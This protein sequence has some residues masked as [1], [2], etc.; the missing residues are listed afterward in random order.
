ML[1]SSHAYY[2]TLGRK[3]GTKTK[4]KLSCQTEIE[5][6]SDLSDSELANLC[7]QLDNC[8]CTQHE[9]PKAKP[10][11]TAKQEYEE[12]VKLA[13]QEWKNHMIF[14]HQVD[15]IKHC[16]CKPLPKDGLPERP[17]K[18]CDFL[19]KLHY[20]HCV[21]HWNSISEFIRQTPTRSHAKKCS[22]AFDGCPRH[23]DTMKDWRPADCYKGYCY[24]DLEHENE[25]QRAVLKAMFKSPPCFCDKLLPNHIGITKNYAFGIS[26]EHE[27]DVY[28]CNCS[29]CYKEEV[30][31]DKFYFYRPLQVDEFKCSLGE[32]MRIPV[33]KSI[34]KEQAN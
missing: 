7:Q 6:D 29:R 19:F 15:L 3:K 11:M 31:S 5:F 1:L 33:P 18:N 10:P 28:Y 16:V 17:C 4:V 24:A 2:F 30:Q 14:Q 8:N 13:K 20:P 12:R 21:A 32:Q 27:D 26:A 34:P 23:D 9:Q 25:G 22:F